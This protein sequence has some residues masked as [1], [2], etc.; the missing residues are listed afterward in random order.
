MSNV[1]KLNVSRVGLFKLY[2]VTVLLFPNLRT[3]FFHVNNQD[4]K[5]RILPF[6]NGADL[7]LYQIMIAGVAMVGYVGL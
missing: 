6:F 2:L 5:I 3:S 4:K 7:D 1:S